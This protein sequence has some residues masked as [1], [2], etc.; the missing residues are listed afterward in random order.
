MGIEDILFKSRDL[1]F[2]FV[3]ECNDRYRNDK[4]LEYYR[5]IVEIHRRLNN[6]EDILRSEGFL[7]LLRDTLIEWDMNKRRAELQDIDV[8]RRN[9]FLHESIL[10]ELYKYKLQEIISLTNDEGVKIISKL[11]FIFKNLN[12]S[13]T[14]RQLVSVSKTL[15]FLLPDLVLPMDGRYTM[16]FYGY[17]N[18]P[19]KIDD[20]FK[21]FKDVFVKSYHISKKLILSTNDI[22]NVMW[23]TSVPKLIDNAIIGFSQEFENFIDHFDDDNVNNYIN[24]LTKYTSFAPHENYPLNKYLDERREKII[25]VE[26]EKAREAILIQKAKDAGITITDEEIYNYLNRKK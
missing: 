23:K 22:D 7:D 14:K 11:N 9:I 5:N 6:I 4:D 10:K 18:I 12:I 17:S 20:Q 19:E 16:N 3:K 26:R 13:K 24:L 1:F 8:I 2:H 21:I 25:K 15:H